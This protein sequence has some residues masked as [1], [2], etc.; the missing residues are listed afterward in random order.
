MKI[1]D[2]FA[3]CGGLSTGFE[4]AGFEVV[5][6]IEKDEWAAETYRFNHPKTNFLTIDITKIH[7][8]NEIINEEVDGVIGGPPCQGFSLSGKRDPKDPRNSLFMDFVRFVSCYKPK[9]F[10]MENVPGLLSAKTSHKESVIKLILNEFDNA[11][12][13]ASYKILNAA[14]FGVPQTRNRVIIIGVRKDLHFDSNN[15]F[16]K[17]FL[18]D[19][20]ISIKDAIMDLPP[21]NSGEGEEEQ[22]YSQQPINDY[23]KYLRRD[24]IAIYNH[25]S[26]RHTQRIIDRFK[27]IK[28]GQSLADVS[29]EHMQRQRGNAKLISGKVYSQNNMRPFGEKPSPT[30]AASFQGNFVHPYFDRNYTAREAARLQSFPDTY[31]FKGK[32]TTMSW[33]K[34]LSQYQQI[35]NAVP[36]LL[37][38]AIALNLLKYFNE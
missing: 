2:L 3:G 5:M 22:N 29:E 9:F 31:I 27:T 6:A 1:I 14:E 11:G 8:P 25:V 12:Y 26:M 20:Q 34:N 28:Q 18:F 24:S 33:E 19:N 36:P 38:K 16:P 32:R 30:I 37:A 10:M 15:L 35:G 21:L 4:M 17:G 13:N 23:Q 7:N